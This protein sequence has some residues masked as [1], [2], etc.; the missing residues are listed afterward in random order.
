MSSSINV[1]K[2]TL[3]DIEA[4]ADLYMKNAN[5]SWTTLTPEATNHGIRQLI[6]DPDKGCQII[7]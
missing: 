2:S 1:R 7:D 5:P 3:N 4:V 6:S